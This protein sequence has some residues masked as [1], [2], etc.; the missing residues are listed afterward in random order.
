MRFRQSETLTVAVAVLMFGIM[1]GFFWT[2]T[3][4]INRAM[5][6]VDGST[7]AIVQSLFNRN[8]RHPMFFSF[9]FGAGAMAVVALLVNYRHHR[10]VSFWLLAVAAVIYIFGI[11]VFTKFVNLPLNYYTESWQ[12]DRLPTDWAAIREQWNRANA[13]RVVTSGLAFILAL[14]ALVTRTR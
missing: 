12:P 14:L 1:A 6:E 7:Y 8:V 4:N 9:F 13:I 10:H 2:Y 5:L 3:F 11:I